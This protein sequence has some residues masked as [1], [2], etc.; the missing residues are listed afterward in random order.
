VARPARA[1]ENAEDFN[2]HGLGGGAGEDGP[3]GGG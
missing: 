2:V 1:A 3:G